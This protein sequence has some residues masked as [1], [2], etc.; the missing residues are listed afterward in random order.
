MKLPT[1]SAL[2]GLS[3]LMFIAGYS[4]PF[5]QGATWYAF[6]LV[7]FGF[8]GTLLASLCE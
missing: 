2:L 8:I 1:I 7:G 4:V 3:C 6:G 5:T